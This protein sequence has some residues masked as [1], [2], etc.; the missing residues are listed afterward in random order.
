M[1]KESA[2]MQL[3]QLGH[4]ARVWEMDCC[5]LIRPVVR[6]LFPRRLLLFARTVHNNFGA[7]AEQLDRRWN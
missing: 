4:R 6:C 2:C 5:Q 7:I 1:A 3:A